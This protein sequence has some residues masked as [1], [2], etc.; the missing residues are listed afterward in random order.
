MKYSE[1]FPLTR[2]TQ[3]SGTFIYA[4]PSIVRIPYCRYPWWGDKKWSSTGEYTYVVPNSAQYMFHTDGM[5]LI[6]EK[7]PLN[8]WPFYVSHPNGESDSPDTLMKDW[9]Q[10]NRPEINK[11]LN[12]IYPIMWA[13][14]VNLK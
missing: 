5:S 7:F 3:D 2:L 13:M 11:F 1:S 9:Q 12:L 8:G 4:C 14:T 6:L 10:A